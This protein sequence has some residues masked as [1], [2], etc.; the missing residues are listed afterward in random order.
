M[1]ACVF[2][3][4]VVVAMGTIGVTILHPQGLWDL[5][6]PPS[7]KVVPTL[8]EDS[9]RMV[10]KDGDPLCIIPMNMAPKSSTHEKDSGD[11]SGPR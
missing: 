6:L 9:S 7:P 8:S 11:Q 3:G 2:S 10:S 1:G 4:G 5:E